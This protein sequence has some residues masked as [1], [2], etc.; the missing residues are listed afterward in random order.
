MEVLNI[1]GVDEKYYRD[2]TSCG[3]PIIMWVNEKVNNF[4]ITLNCKYGSIDT[5]FTVD[6]ETYTVPNG[7]AHFLEHVNFA[8]PGGKDATDYFSEL[9]SSSNAFTTTEYTSY[10]VYASSNFK[11]NLEHLLDFVYTPYF[12]EANVKK[13]KGIITEEVKMGKNN[14]GHVFYYGANDCIYVKDKRK[15]LV[16]GEVEDVKKTTKEDLQLV[17]D[18]FYHPKN[19]FLVIT[20]NFNPFEASAIVKENM[21]NKEFGVYKE[22]IKKRINEPLMV[23]VPYK[24]E[25]GNVELPKIKITYKI[26]RDNFRNIDD[27]ELRIYTGMLLR[28]NF[29][30]TSSF[31]EELLENELITMLSY[32]RE[33]NNNILIISI[34]VETKY[35]TEVIDKVRDKMEN[36]SINND[37]L[38]RRKRCN[39]AALIN[40][41]DDIEYINSEIQDSIITYGEIKTDMYDVYSNCKVDT[42]NRVIK[43]INTENESIFIFKSK[44]SSS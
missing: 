30:A 17:Y 20:G 12:T 42:A 31:K 27:L 38:I 11:E 4:Y 37:D 25:T 26:D 28:N 5:E 2:E 40:D 43:G 8:L 21:G 41:Y 34:V 18:T 23:N 13:E 9:G 32:E 29:G 44:K 22:P 7:V 15:Y 24:E 16:T 35:P 3:L 36:L 10:E 19:M 1:S 14:P 33:I 39:I 6:N